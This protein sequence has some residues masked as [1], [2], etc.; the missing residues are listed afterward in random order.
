MDY[1]SERKNRKPNSR[2]AGH[3]TSKGNGLNDQG[4]ATLL[5]LVL[6]AILSTYGLEMYLKAHIENK[7]VRREITSRQA[8]YA[9]EGG[10]E[11]VRANLKENLDFIGGQLELGEGTVEVSVN[12]VDVENGYEV[13][14]NAQYGLARR[15]L[16]VKL[17]KMSD[18]WEITE[19][20]ELFD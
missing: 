8:V 3:Y 9:A 14:S 15:R 1:N 18:S 10:V 5:I 13:I 7:M 6:F 19:Y 11:W 2:V 16:K 17:E 20:Q 4:F 12:K